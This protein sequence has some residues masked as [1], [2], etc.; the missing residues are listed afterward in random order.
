MARRCRLV[1]AWQEA[2]YSVLEIA[3]DAATIV[4]CW[5]RRAAAQ[6]LLQRRKDE[7]EKA[8]FVYGHDFTANEEANWAA[9][10]LPIPID[11]ACY[12]DEMYRQ[13]IVWV[14]RSACVDCVDPDEAERLLRWSAPPASS[15]VLQLIDYPPAPP[16]CLSVPVP[17]SVPVSVLPGLITSSTENSDANTNTNTNTNTMRN[18]PLLHGHLLAMVQLPDDLYSPA[19]E[20][21]GTQFSRIGN[22]RNKVVRNFM[23]GRCDSQLG[24]FSESEGKGM[25]IAS[26]EIDNNTLHRQSRCGESLG[27]ICVDSSISDTLDSL[28]PRLLSSAIEW[29]DQFNMLAELHQENVDS[30]PPIYAMLAL[31][32]Q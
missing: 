1:T 16:G 15:E 28:D 3:H 23:Y 14:P 4:Q 32:F 25:D 29:E 18:S 21:D 20:S 26:D 17:V 19:A 2:V 12:L 6:R 27:D 8:H 11:D 9:F 10:G 30:L 13:P 31:R 22:V 5:L 24:N 7:Y